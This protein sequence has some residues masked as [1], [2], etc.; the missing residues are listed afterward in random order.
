MTE[1]TA[2][3]AD[4][5]RRLLSAVSGVVPEFIIAGG[6]AARLLRLHPPATRLEWNPLLTSDTDVATA[7]KGRPGLHTPEAFAL[8]NRFGLRE[9]LG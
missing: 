2:E 7:D 1:L 8:A 9:L 4:F 3:E 6:Q 5:F